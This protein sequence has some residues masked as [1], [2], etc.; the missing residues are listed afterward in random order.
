MHNSY[1]TR[2]CKTQVNGVKHSC[3]R[4]VA[5]D[6][7]VD[8]EM[9]REGLFDD[10]SPLQRIVRI[11][12]IHEDFQR[13]VAVRVPNTYPPRVDPAEMMSDAVF[14]SHFRFDKQSVVR[15]VDELG[16]HRE[17]NRGLPINPQ[18]ALCICL[19][20]LAGG[21]YQRISALCIGNVSKSTAHYAIK[22]V[23]S[24]ILQLKSTYMKM[25][26]R[27][28]REETAAYVLE[29]YKLPGFAYG[30]DGMLVKF[31]QLPRGIPV[32]AGYPV[33][34]SFWTRKAC[35]GIPAPTL[36]NERHLILAVDKDWQGSAHDAVIWEHS[37]FKTIVEENREHLVA[38]D[39]AFPISDVLIKPYTNE[40]LVSFLIY[41]CC[42]DGAGAGSRSR[43][44]RHF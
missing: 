18:Q 32:G 40:V 41:P 16:L 14:K 15:L 25:P 37:L 19:C 36:G 6:N 13:A 10:E 28:E 2:N 9:D 11:N 38:G 34:Q 1:V 39:S 20:H 17:N 12:R 35:P 44:S 27:Q 26:T 8:Y 23:R 21:H 29:K 31:E 30:I 43:W 33:A 22:D 42:G 7:G 3:Y 5:M 24:R 4:F